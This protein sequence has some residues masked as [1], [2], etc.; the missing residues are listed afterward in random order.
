M[1]IDDEEEEEYSETEP[2]LGVRAE[3]SKGTAR[4]SYPSLGQVTQGLSALVLLTW[5]V[6]S[7]G[8]MPVALRVMFYSEATG[9]ACMALAT[10][11]EDR[12]G[13]NHRQDEPEKP[14]RNFRSILASSNMFVSTL[15]LVSYTAFI[16]GVSF[17]RFSIATAGFG[18]PMFREYPGSFAVRVLGCTVFAPVLISSLAYA[19]AS[20]WIPV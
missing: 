20:L 11:L 10:V 1:D 5:V 17:G 13:E 9:Q 7:R 16:L 8:S 19:C 12:H 2:I 18:Y 14:V 4:S 3:G 6:V 15:G